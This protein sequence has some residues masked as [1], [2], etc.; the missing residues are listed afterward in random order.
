[1]EIEDEAWTTAEADAEAL[2]WRAAQAVLDAHEDI[3]G[4]G[5]VI[6][7][8]DDDSVQALNRDFR[9]KD[10]AT[11]VLSF[12]SPPNPE[13]QIGDIALAYGVCAREAAEQGKPLAHHLQHLVAHGVLH[14]LGYDHERDDEAE[15]M[16]ALEREILAG[17]DVPDPYA[18]DEEGR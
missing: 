12:P 17:L 11:N 7:L 5:I 16:E 3:E 6:L 10:Y 14:L 2:V 9:K 4:Q 1:M 18:S 13:G 8:T 15:A